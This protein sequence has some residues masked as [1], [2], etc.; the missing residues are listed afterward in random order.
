MEKDIVEKLIEDIEDIEKDGIELFKM[1]PLKPAERV[2]QDGDE[3]IVLRWF[4]NDETSDISRKIRRRYE[5][6]YQAGLKLIEKY[7]PY[8]AQEFKS[9]YDVMISYVTLNRYA[10]TTPTILEEVKTRHELGYVGVYLKEF[11]NVIDSQA[12]LIRS[13]LYLPDETIE[14]TYK[15]FLTGFPAPY[16]LRANPNFVFVV[17]PFS[18]SYDDIYQI[19]IKEVATRLG[20]QCTRSDEII[21]TQNVICTAICQPIRAARIVIAEI[22]EKNPNVY[23]ELGL[24]HARSE[25]NNQIDK[26]VIILTQNMENVPFDLRNMSIIHYDTIGD[27]RSKLTLALREFTGN[28][29]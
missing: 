4:L 21:H 16:D 8:Q 29:D 13:I 9:V 15:C 27:L 7:L 5:A 18:K 12:N 26:K 14:S 17:M 11:P 23:Y 2:K 20:L 6:W 19:G 25:D 24:T 22:T 1:V 28:F 10:T 3:L